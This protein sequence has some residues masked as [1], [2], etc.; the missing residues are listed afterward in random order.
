MS[1]THQLGEQQNNKFQ[2]LDFN[3]CVF[4]TKQLKWLVKLSWHLDFAIGKVFI[5][6]CVA[7]QQND[8]ENAFKQKEWRKKSDLNLFFLLLSDKQAW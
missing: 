5:F 2:Y 8:S 7:P 4:V 6:V 3:V 1:L